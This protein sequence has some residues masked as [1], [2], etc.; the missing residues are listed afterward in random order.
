MVRPAGG[1]VEFGG[2]RVAG[3]LS[4]LAVNYRK[5]ALVE[6]H[7]AGGRRAGGRAP[8]SELRDDG[9]QARRIFEV[10]RAPRH[11]LLIFLGI[12]GT[13]EQAE[14]LGNM[15]SAFQA[16]VM[17]SYRIARGRTGL[18]AELRDLSGLAHAAYGLT[19]G[20]LI[21]VRPDGYIGY[22]STHFGE[23]P[24]RTYLSRLFLR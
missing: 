20:G 15:L 12:S 3:R 11:V 17:D 1:G 10:L 14:Q 2:A 24:L 4:E 6:N 9:N 13:T 18:P 5:S 7:G 8:D 23:N 22:R 19:S 16:D 21:L